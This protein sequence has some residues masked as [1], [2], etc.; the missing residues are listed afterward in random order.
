M[1]EER[2]KNDLY[3]E[4]QF[5]Q[6]FYSACSECFKENRALRAFRK[7]NTETHADLLKKYPALKK[8]DAHTNRKIEEN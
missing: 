5:H 2:M 8:L 4:H 3:Q 6:R 7:V 1:I